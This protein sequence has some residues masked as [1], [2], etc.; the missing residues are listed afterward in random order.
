MF[1]Y[2]LSLIAICKTKGR[3]HALSKMCLARKTSFE[4]LVEA[5]TDSSYILAISPVICGFIS[6]IACIYVC[7][8]AIRGGFTPCKPMT[9]IHKNLSLQFKQKLQRQKLSNSNIQHNLMEEI[10]QEPPA[11]YSDQNHPTMMVDI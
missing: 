11:R 10:Q 5:M 7:I 6:V 3:R 4:V 2:L 8:S 1:T 9:R